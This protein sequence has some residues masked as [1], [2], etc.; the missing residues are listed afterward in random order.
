[1]NISRKFYDWALAAISSH[2]IPGIP[3]HEDQVHPHYGGFSIANL[4]DSICRWLAI[5]P[6]NNNALD[7][8]ILKEIGEDYKHV[9]LLLVDGLTLNL[10]NRFI[11]EDADAN[12]F[13]DWADN[14]EGSLYLPLSS[15]APST[16]SAVLTTLWT[17]CTPSQHGITG[18][19]LFLKKFGL[20]ANMITHSVAS[21]ITQPQNISQAGFDPR[22]FL[23]VKTLGEHFKTHA[24]EPYT[25]QHQTIAS[26]GL[27]EMLLQHVHRN[28]FDT[29]EDLWA[30]V[31]QLLAN[32]SPGKS[33]VYL[34]WGGLDTLSHHIGPNSRELYREWVSFAASLSRFLKRLRGLA[35]PK[36]LFILTADHG[37]APTQINANYDLHN[38]P[39][40]LENLI[41]SP[42]GES[43]L[44]Y[45]YIK[46][47]KEE[48]VHKYLA[49]HWDGDFSILDSETVLKSG[50]LGAQ[51]TPNFTLERMGS[52]VAFP[53]GN[54]Y[55]W[56]VNKGNNLLGRHGGLS[57]EEMLVPFLA[58]PL[59]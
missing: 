38:H 55:W 40:F 39:E 27:S 10:F 14:L 26:S 2:R 35:L 16:T 19:E 32:R 3:L 46:T 49:D 7:P 44:P 33:Y 42:T 52:H 50:L 4:A 34:Y 58:V 51:S 57:S 37:Q 24:V 20:V 17:G 28:T 8:A 12:A 15:I 23:P 25:F 36:T 11:I 22:T 56:W 48:S 13:Q 31:E 1:M 43:R 45:L 59:K 6:V 5:P 47:G 9:I 29:Q 18:Y 54:T 53:R 30:S 21:F 41:M